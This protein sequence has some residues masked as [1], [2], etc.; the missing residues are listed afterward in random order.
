M[1]VARGIGDR[2]ARFAETHAMWKHADSCT[3]EDLLVA[4]ADTCWK[5]KRAE[6]LEELVCSHLLTRVSGERWEVFAALDGIVEALAAH[7]D[8][9]LA[10]QSRY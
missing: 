4:L 6:R 9:R 2:Y 8:R 5:G 7:A 10:W 3:F 1:L